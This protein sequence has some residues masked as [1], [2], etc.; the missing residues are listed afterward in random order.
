VST[1]PTRNQRREASAQ[2]RA[3]RIA[4]DQ[5]K[6]KQRRLFAVIGGAVVIA[7]VAI[8]VLAIINRDNDNNVTLAAVQPV[9]TID[10][11]IPRSGMTLGSETAPVLI[12]EYGDYQCPFCAQFNS[13][14]FQTLLS[15]Y[16]ATGQVRMQFSPFSFLGDESTDAAEAA[17]C[18]NDQGKFWEMHETIYGNQ[19]GE[20]EGAFSK[21]RLAEMAQMA[22]LDMDAYN[23]CMA[24]G[25]HSSTVT[26][27]NQAANAAGVTST[28]SF[29]INGG[30]AFGFS[31][32]EDFEA[33]IQAA[34]GE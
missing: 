31:S 28:P 10:S 20:N 13:G 17:L 12:V 22:G 25:T 7:I 21:E 19:I 23:S 26:D 27:L 8:A 14:A 33:R 18:A 2:A 34:L 30:E 11:S 9:S 4:A 29:T 3:A 32:W 5:K 24:D 6:S 1:K 15:Q 16:I